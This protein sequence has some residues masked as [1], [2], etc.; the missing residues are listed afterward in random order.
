MKDIGPLEIPK[1][2]LERNIWVKIVVMNAIFPVDLPI[3]PTCISW[4]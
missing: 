1:L 2:R 3:S 4:L